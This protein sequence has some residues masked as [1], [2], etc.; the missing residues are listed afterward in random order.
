MSVVVASLQYSM[1]KIHIF[2]DFFHKLFLFSE[3]SPLHSWRRESRVQAQIIYA[4]KMLSKYQ[5]FGMVVIVNEMKHERSSIQFQSPQN[6]SLKIMGLS[7]LL[8]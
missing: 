2:L 5:Y 6:Q 3:F 4:D 7:C 8:F 1:A